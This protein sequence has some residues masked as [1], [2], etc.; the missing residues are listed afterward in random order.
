MI[1]I[2]N[3]SIK[4]KLI[5]L[6]IMLSSMFFIS[7]GHAAQ[8]AK[9]QGSDER[10]QVFKYEPSDVFV[11]NTK[12]GYSTLIQLEDNEVIHDEGGLGMGDADAWSLAVRGNNI[13]FKPISDLPDTNMIVVTNKRTYAFQLTTTGVAPTYIARFTYPDE[14]T[15]EIQVNKMPGVLRRV[16]TDNEGNNILIDADINTNYWWRGDKQI[17]P[18]NVWDNGRFTMLKFAHASDL[19]TVYRVLPDQTEMLVNTHIEGDTMIIQE[20][21]DVYRLRFGKSVADIGN[22]SAKLPDFNETGT[23]DDD[24][25]RINQ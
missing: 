12:V 16:G 25:I 1:K 21:A 17:V 14:R 7:H 4:R 11:I 6:P 5:C 24:F 22:A 2:A 19:P 8:I 23:S 10:V 20:T 13:F 18:T 15:S 9:T 3:K